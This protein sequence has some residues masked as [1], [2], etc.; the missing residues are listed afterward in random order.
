MVTKSGSKSKSATFS[1]A[2]AMVVRR[3]CGA[4]ALPI[5]IHHVICNT[6]PGGIDTGG[7][8]S[9]VAFAQACKTLLF[10]FSFAFPTR[11][12]LALQ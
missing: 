2:A 4:R 9:S 11:P 5:L 1:E 6:R 8:V 12:I 3:A 10:V 7:C